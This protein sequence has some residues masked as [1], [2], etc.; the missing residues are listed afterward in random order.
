MAAS[1][2]FAVE[3]AIIVTSVVALRRVRRRQRQAERTV[4]ALLDAVRTLGRIDDVRDGA[5]T[6]AL[7]AAQMLD[8]D[9]TG[10]FLA[11]LR[12]G[13]YT[14]SSWLSHPSLMHCGP[15]TL[16]LMEAE[17]SALARGECLEVR[18]RWRVDRL[19]GPDAA[20]CFQFVHLLPLPDQRGRTIG[21]IAAYFGSGFNRRECAPNDAAKLLCDEAGRM[22]GRLVATAE[23]ERE[24]HTDPLT[25]LANRRTYLHALERLMP[26]DA[27][28]MLD[29]D[30]FKRVNDEHGHAAGDDVLR[31]LAHCLRSVARQADTV[32]RYGGEEFTL[33]LP[34]AG[35]HGAQVTLAR[36]VRAWRALDPLTSFSAGV[37]VH[38]DGDDVMQTVARA[39]GALYRAKAEGRDRIVLADSDAELVLP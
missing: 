15:L 5:R 26:G 14:H 21:V 12:R 28:V 23:L 11:T 29:L 17:R 39:D 24:A 10:V 30:H 9:A 13:H 35:E 27:V 33:V 18:D 19:S 37:A 38:R 31:D 8:A 36:L 20:N 3:A 1:P 22:F 4:E 2:H 32:A 25:Q 7:L 6:T 16:N 34:E